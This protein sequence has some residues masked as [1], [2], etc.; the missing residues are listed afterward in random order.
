MAGEDCRVLAP[1][2]EWPHQLTNH[3]FPWHSLPPV[4]SPSQNK[5]HFCKSCLG[6]YVCRTVERMAIRWSIDAFSRNASSGP[7][8]SLI[9][10]FLV[11]I[12]PGPGTNPEFESTN[13]G[14]TSSDAIRSPKRIAAFLR[15]APNN[16]ISG[17]ITPFL[18]LIT[19]GP[20][21]TPEYL[22]NCFGFYIFR[23]TVR[24]ALRWSAR[25]DAFSRHVLN[26]AV[27]SI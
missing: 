13:R 9:S 22:V 8:I 27:Y 16:P 19:P 17:L 14:C 18:V 5:P 24:M 21:T 15:H 23:M 20:G 12:T 11:F 2:T 26:G 6:F 3:T 1:R 4:L 25:I 7:I 10:P